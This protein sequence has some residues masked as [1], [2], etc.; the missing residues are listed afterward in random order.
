M[1]FFLQNDRWVDNFILGIFIDKKKIF[2]I[3]YFVL[4]N[5]VSKF[6]LTRNEVI[7]EFFRSFV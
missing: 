7:D 6:T 2:M 1:Y 5:N 4:Y 3:L